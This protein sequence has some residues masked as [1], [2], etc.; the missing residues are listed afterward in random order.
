[1][2]KKLISNCKKKKQWFREWRNKK[3][4]NQYQYTFFMRTSKFWGEAGCS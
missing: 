2:Q 1:M 3:R 4:N